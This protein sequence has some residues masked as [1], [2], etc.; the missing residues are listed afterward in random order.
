M[1]KALIALPVLLIIVLIAAMFSTPAADT[2]TV[3]V[4]VPLES[5]QQT[6]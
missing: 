2:K 1:K 3:E 5:L 4:D 6:P